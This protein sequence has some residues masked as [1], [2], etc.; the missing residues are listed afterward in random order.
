[1]LNKQV[2]QSSEVRLSAITHFFVPLRV[3]I[4]LDLNGANFVIFPSGSCLITSFYQYIVTAF[5]VH[6]IVEYH[7]SLFFADSIAFAFNKRSNLHFVSLFY[8][9]LP[10]CQ[11]CILKIWVAPSNYS[12][13]YSSLTR[14][15]P[16]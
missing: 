12:Q 1:M 7:N 8:K 6:S 9:S 3:H 4:H 15:F 5:R 14:Q 2:L 10:C 16:L 13:E 11:P